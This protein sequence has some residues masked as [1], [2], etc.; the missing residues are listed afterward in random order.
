MNGQETENVR[1]E[2]CRLNTECAGM[3]FGGGS[4]MAH[5]AIDSVFSSSNPPPQEAH[6]AAQQLAQ[7]PEEPCNRQ[8]K[9]FAD[10][11]SERGGDLESCRSNQLLS[12][13]LFFPA[14]PLYLSYHLFV[15]SLQNVLTQQ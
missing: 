14:M 9:T 5:R 6:Q 2:D 7:T 12:A 11:M 15:P 3:A 10:C 13:S 8:A 4:A 1:F